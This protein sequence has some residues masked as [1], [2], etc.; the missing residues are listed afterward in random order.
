MTF[1]FFKQQKGPRSDNSKSNKIFVGGIPHN[2]GET[3][4]REYFKKFGVVSSS[5]PAALGS[6]CSAQPGQSGSGK[7]CVHREALPG[8]LVILA[9]MTPGQNKPEPHPSHSCPHT[10]QESSHR[11]RETHQAGIQEA[12]RR[13]C[14]LSLNHRRACSRSGPPALG[15]L[16]VG[17]AILAWWRSSRAGGRSQVFVPLSRGFWPSPMLPLA[18][19][20]AL[21]PIR[22][23]SRQDIWPCV[24]LSV[25]LCDTS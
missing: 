14:L 16:C 24:L 9:C 1:S 11:Q 5:T 21:W 18:A 13:S 17:L 7:P 22:H 6:S 15:P 4:L 23:D 10:T 2:C 25:F 3:E 20:T 8:S 12:F 19:L